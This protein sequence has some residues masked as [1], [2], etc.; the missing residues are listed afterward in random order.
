[1]FIDL[2]IAAL[3]ALE[4]LVSSGEKDDISTLYQKGLA[5]EQLNPRELMGHYC[6]CLQHSNTIV[7]ALTRTLCGRRVTSDLLVKASSPDEAR[8]R[9]VDTNIIE[10]IRDSDGLVR[11]LLTMAAFGGLPGVQEIANVEN[12]I[13]Y[14]DDP[15]GLVRLVISKLAKRGILLA[16]GE[17]MSRL[18]CAL[19]RDVVVVEFSGNTCTALFSS[20]TPKRSIR[21]SKPGVTIEP[22]PGS[23]ELPMPKLN[24]ISPDSVLDAVVG[25]GTLGSSSVP[26]TAWEMELLSYMVSRLDSVRVTPA[27]PA[28]RSGQ[29]GR[30]GIVTVN[31]C[32]SCHSIHGVSPTKT[33]KA[34]RVITIFGVAGPRCSGCGSCSVVRI[35]LS[36]RVLDFKLPK[37]RVLFAPCTECAEVCAVHTVYGDLPFCERHSSDAAVEALNRRAVACAI[38]HVSLHGE[39]SGMVIECEDDLHRLCFR[40]HSILPTTRWTKS[41]FAL[42]QSR[43]GLNV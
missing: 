39:A 31:F 37:S 26:K 41:E 23:V 40:C 28:A 30:V 12:R 24:A 1:M 11:R 35:D 9:Y 14:W 3:M 25:F 33:S 4:E 2:H 8:V 13:R 32:V 42:L 19:L 18:P 20:P 38:C 6:G 17:A 27:D 5:P 43:K 15:E 21:V 10:S 7:R 22:A 29:I 36:G 16:L 34:Q